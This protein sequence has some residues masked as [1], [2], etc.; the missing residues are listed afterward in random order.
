MDPQLQQTILDLSETHGPENL[1]VVLGMSDAED[2]K[3]YA[4]TVTTGDPSDAGA[5]SGVSLGLSVYHIFD[6]EMEAIVP[7]ETWAK[8]IAPARLD[9]DG[10]ALAQTVARIRSTSSRYAL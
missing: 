6:A 2:A 8:Q 1:L 5:L 7:P 4:E 3:L 10:D 9:L